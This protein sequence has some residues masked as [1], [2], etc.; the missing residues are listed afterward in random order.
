MPP[1]KE[2]SQSQ[3]MRDIKNKKESEDPK[4]LNCEEKVHSVFDP[5]EHKVRVLNF[6]II[7][8][9]YDYFLGVWKVSDGQWD[10]NL[11]WGEQRWQLRSN[12]V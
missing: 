3:K 8:F 7:L 9:K 1:K 4:G 5:V 6:K 10:C 2:V 12:C 11:C